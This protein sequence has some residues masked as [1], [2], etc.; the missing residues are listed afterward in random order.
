MNRSAL[1]QVDLALNV[2]MWDTGNFCKPRNSYKVA[3]V[4]TYTCVVWRAALFISVIVSE[5]LRVSGDSRE[6]IFPMISS[7]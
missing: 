6:Q 2:V 7:I 1:A 5:D 3:K 4:E